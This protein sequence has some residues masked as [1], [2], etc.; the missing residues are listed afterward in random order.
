MTT[1]A[2]HRPGPLALRVWGNP[3]ARGV[4]R[5][6]AALTWILMASWLMAL[7]I[8]AVIGSVQWA[9]LQA[10]ADAQARSLVS[11][12][13]VLVTDAGY[14]LTNYRSIPT[15]VTAEATWVGRSG[16]DVTG[17]VTPAP[18]ARAGEHLTIW[19]DPDGAIVAAPMSATDA[20]VQ[21]VIIV[22]FGWTV[23]ALLLGTAWWVVR[24][25]FD[26]R[27][28]QAWA[29]EWERVEPDSR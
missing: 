26:R 4:D 11:V 9:D 6:E 25:R 2:G 28:W 7:P 18:G 22:T 29:Q 3:L 23:L 1:R 19:L 12:E 27:R 13:A 24:R 10:R 17:P 14:E 20:A 8:L 5:A 16:L 15:G 21:A